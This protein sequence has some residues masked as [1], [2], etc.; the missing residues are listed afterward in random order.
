MLGGGGASEPTSA[1]ERWSRRPCAFTN[2]RWPVCV[3]EAASVHLGMCDV[4]T[5][6][7]AAPGK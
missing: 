7:S 5:A 1:P 6:G 4:R 2:M 3:P